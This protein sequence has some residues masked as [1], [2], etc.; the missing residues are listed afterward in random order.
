ME[1]IDYLKQK[2]TIL[3]NL[4][5]VKKYEE[6][7]DKGIPLIKKYPDQV[8]FYNAVS[9]AYNQL[10]K[11]DEAKNLLKRCLKQNPNN[12]F[13]IN[14]LGLVLSTS[15]EDIEAEKYFKEALKLKPDYIDSLVNLGNLKMRQNKSQEAKE[16]YLT[17]LKIN[18]NLEAINI[19]LAHCYS[20]IGDFTEAKKIYLK[21]LE[22]NPNNTSADKSLS[23][24]HKYKSK[25]DMHLKSLEKKINNISNEFNLA[26]LNFS[27]GK[28]YEDI[29]EY[30]KAFNCYKSGNDIL[31]KV[32]KYDIEKDKKLFQNLKNLFDSNKIDNLSDA[33]RK[34]IFIVGMPRSGTTLVEQILSSHSK[35]Y[36]AG[37][38]S[39]LSQTIDKNILKPN[40]KKIKKDELEKIQKDYI[41]K[42]S[43]FDYDQKYI[44]DK[45]PLNFRWIGFIIKVFPNSKIIHCKRDSMDICWSNFKNTFSS[46]LQDYSYNFKSL[47]S[48]YKLYD[49]LMNFWNN[50]FKENIFELKYE[51]LVSNLEDETKKLLKFCELKW[52]KNC[53]EFHKNKKTVSTASV[54]QVREPIYNTSVKKWEKFSNQLKNLKDELQS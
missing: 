32:K 41:S 34:I 20:Q 21:I 6:L 22:N 27:L 24:I 40:L 28:A 2:A 11:F 29:K 43:F 10:K 36:G 37:E 38:L 50:K 18:K 35:V 12:I 31:S 44:V 39:F 3:I 53:L 14:N 4:Y 48:Y 1:N 51:N 45:A 13:V 7:I 5:N 15:G 46:S 8:V 23:Q 25:D 30:Q 49:E 54:A 19:S 42:L 33:T 26:Q 9:L 16:L 17:A 52:D 47:S